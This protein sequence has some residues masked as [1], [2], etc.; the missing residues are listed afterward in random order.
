MNE[1]FLLALQFSVSTALMR[2]TSPK[3]VFHQNVSRVAAIWHMV[4]LGKALS[5]VGHSNHAEPECTMYS[6]WLIRIYTTNVYNIVLARS[7]IS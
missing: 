6:K 7:H 2:A 3:Q 1:H 5:A 4:N